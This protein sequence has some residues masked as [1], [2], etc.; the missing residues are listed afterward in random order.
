MEFEALSPCN[1]QA[2]P[3]SRWFLPAAGLAALL[4]AAL[5]FCFD[6]PEYMRIMRA[7]MIVPFKTPFIDAQAV[8]ATVECARRGIDVFISVP[9][10]PLHRRWDYSPLWLWATFLPP[11][12]NWMGICLD[13]SFFLSLALL[14][15]AR[16]RTGLLIIALATF[17][18]VP[19]F[20]LERGNVDLI[21]FVLIALGGA[22]WARSFG[23]RLAGYALFGVA[24]FLKFYPLVLFALFL[25]ERVVR[26]VLLGCT[27]FALLAAFILQYHAELRQ[28]AANM[29]VFL[30]FTDAFVSHQLPRG[31]ELAIPYLLRASGLN[32]PFLVTIRAQ[33][34]FVWDVW[35]ALTVASL[36]FSLWLAGQPKTASA[37]SQIDGSERGFLVIG[38]ALMCCNFFACENDSYRA[39]FLL[40]TIPGMLRLASVPSTRRIFGV[41]AATTLFVMWGLTVQAAIAKLSGGLA[42]PMSESA[43]LLVYWIV[44]ELAWWWLISILLCVLV[45]FIEGSPMWRALMRLRHRRDAA[46]ARA[47][48]A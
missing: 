40:F 34:M 41:A 3:A 36:A 25:R 33:A 18:S 26:F 11:W 12:A 4:I 38:A 13:A 48:D 27:G 45:R 7:L 14:P 15:P 29:P 9:C 39:I 2:R 6:T 8:P 37:F 47:A 24:G 20:A 16:G 43:T 21:M 42:Y 30:E 35:A 46:L 19:A 17:S 22:L 31:L 28:A 5:A 1:R 32:W 10:D 44:R 23:L